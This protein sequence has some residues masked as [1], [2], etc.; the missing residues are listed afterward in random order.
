M[1][2]VMVEWEVTLKCNYN[3]DYC[4]LLR[5][6]QECT[7]KSKLTEFIE[8]LNSS[9]P[10]VQIFIF[11]GEPFL[12]PEIEFIIN[13]LQRVNQKFVIQSN[14]SNKSTKVIQSLNVKPFKL[15][16]STHP[17][18]TNITDAVK[19]ITAVQPDEVHLMYTECTGKVEQYYNIIDKVKG[20]SKLVL[21]PVSNLGC[22]GYDKVLHN[23]NQIREHYNFDK[24]KIM[25]NST[26]MYRSDIW[27]LQNTT[28]KSLTKGKPCMYLD[29]YVLFDPSLNELNCCYR[30]NHG[31]VCNE[32]N[33]FFM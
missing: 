7:D 5:P 13:E 12:H 32:Q 21:T 24:N 3:C 1:S 2:E 9:Y 25:Y 27:E 16:A 14:L 28:T 19:N 31:E 22:T 17:S 10:D 33:C 20:S 26:E 23:Y 15:F 18:M 29:R 11:G 30:K 8:K 4:G 6:I